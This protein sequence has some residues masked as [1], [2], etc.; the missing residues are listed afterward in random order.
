MVLFFVVFCEDHCISVFILNVLF[1]GNGLW[2]M[3]SSHQRKLADALSLSNVS[4]D[5]S[6]YKNNHEHRQ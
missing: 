6:R 2:A 4:K 5:F 3:L 1:E